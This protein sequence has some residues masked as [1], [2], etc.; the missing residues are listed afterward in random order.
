LLPSL[1]FPSSPSFFLLSFQ[2]ER[3]SGEYANDLG[4]YT[5][6]SDVWSL[7]LSII[8]LAI[9]KYPY[10]PEVFSSPFAQLQAIVYSEPPT[11]P[12]HYSAEAKDFV[13]QWYVSF[14]SPAH[15]FLSLSSYPCV[16]N[17]DSC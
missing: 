17:G 7:G 13:A 11:L 9:G 6:S 16:L 14:L 2:P 1:S 10:P 5:V 3:I 4:I 15:L 8:E 12:E